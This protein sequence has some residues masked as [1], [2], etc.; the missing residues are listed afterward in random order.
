MLSIA[1]SFCLVSMCV[2]CCFTRRGGHCVWMLLCLAVCKFGGF[3][4]LEQWMFLC[5]EVFAFGGCFCL[6]DFCLGAFDLPNLTATEVALK[7]NDDAL[8][9]ISGISLLFQPEGMRGP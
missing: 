8:L 7:E 5:L 6:D 2:L 9:Q 1:L 3:C 4:V